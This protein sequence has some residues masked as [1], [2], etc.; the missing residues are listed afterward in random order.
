MLSTLISFFSSVVL[1]DLEG[2]TLDN[3]FDPS[4]DTESSA[5]KMR[6]EANL[7]TL[8]YQYIQNNFDYHLRVHQG[9]AAV[10][11]PQWR[12][13]IHEFPRHWVTICELPWR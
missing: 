12:A 9:V 2:G 8:D 3:V 7:T 1:R 13:T 6:K 5:P 10:N 11:Y 4:Q